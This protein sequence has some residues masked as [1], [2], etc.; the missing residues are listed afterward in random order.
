MMLL[1][2]KLSYK[3]LRIEF[4]T[5]MTP[6]LQAKCTTMYDQVLFYV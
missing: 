2:T 6:V 4:Y 5:H 1:K 3:E